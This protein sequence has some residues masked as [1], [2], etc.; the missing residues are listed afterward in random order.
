MAAALSTTEPPRYESQLRRKNASLD[1]AAD[2]INDAGEVDELLHEM[3]KDM[4]REDAKTAKAAAKRAAR[5]AAKAKAKPTAK[6]K[7]K[8][9]K[10]QDPPPEDAAMEVAGEDL[11]SNSDDEADEDAKACAALDAELG[12]DECAESTVPY[13]PD[14]YEP[15]PHVTV[16]HIYSNCYKRAMVKGASKEVAADAARTQTLIFRTHAVVSKTMVGTFRAPKI[17][18]PD[19]KKKTKK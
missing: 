9:K 6:P 1:V 17:S 5:K 15:P 16:N 10:A 19:A 13:P 2:A 14:A 4:E 18:K 3:E 11:C 12:E 8:A 7:R